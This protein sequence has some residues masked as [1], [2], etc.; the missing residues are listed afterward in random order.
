MYV[1]TY[2]CTQLREILTSSGYSNSCTQLS[3]LTRQTTYLTHF[4]T[5]PLNRK[6]NISDGLSIRTPY[7]VG[8]LFGRDDVEL[9]C[10]KSIWKTPYIQGA[11]FNVTHFESRITHLLYTAI[12]TTEHGQLSQCLGFT[13]SLTSSLQRLGDVLHDIQGIAAISQVHLPWR[14]VQCPA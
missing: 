11:A 2:T 10:I 12:N 1:T 3:V 5:R 4:L 13:K 14:N 6:S 8:R 9:V 7:F